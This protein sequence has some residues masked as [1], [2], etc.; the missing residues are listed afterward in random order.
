MDKILFSKSVNYFSGHMKD[1][2]NSYSQIKEGSF[3][4]PLMLPPKV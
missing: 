1:A 3:L 2:V 4:N